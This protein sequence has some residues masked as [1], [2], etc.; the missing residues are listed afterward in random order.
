MNRIVR[1]FTKEEL[2]LADPNENVYDSINVMRATFSEEL[3]A[4]FIRSK[5]GTLLYVNDILD[6]EEQAKV[7]K[8]I[9]K[10][11][12]KCGIAE[13][14]VLRVNFEYYCGGTC[15]DNRFRPAI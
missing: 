1:F 9:E 7:I 2:C 10:E 14:G 15:C 3:L 11:I 8:Y 12:D 5:A 6:P 4:F 13:A